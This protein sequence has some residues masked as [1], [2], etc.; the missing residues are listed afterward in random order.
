[1]KHE[2]SISALKITNTIMMW[3][4]CL[5]VMMLVMPWEIIST[6]FASHIETNKIVLYFA[7]IIEVSNFISQGLL[8]IINALLSKKA[9][10]KMQEKIVQAVEGLDFAER[11]L[12]REYVLQR[13]SVLTLPVN[14]PTVRNL[15]DDGVLRIVNVNDSNTYRADIIIAK[16]ARPYITYK[17]IGLTLGKMTEE[18]VTQ[19]MNSRPEY[20]KQKFSHQNKIFI[21]ANAV[22]NVNTPMREIEENNEDVAA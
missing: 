21:G 15:I 19:I 12:L 9:Q 4:F 20:A 6:E 17:A 16:E 2:N 1:M 18:Q 8:T 22:R 10:K 3:L 11:A 7:L 14:E 5:T 13:K